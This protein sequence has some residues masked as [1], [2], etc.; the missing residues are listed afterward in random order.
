[1]PLRISWWFM[2]VLAVAIGAYAL[3]QALLPVARSPLVAGMLAFSSLGSLTHFLAGSLVI[4]IGA[5]QLSKWLRQRNLALHRWLGRVY[6]IGV[7]FGGIAG[8]VMA[9]N[10]TGGP[11]THLGFGMLAVLWL[12]TT[13]KA[14]LSIRAGNIKEHRAWMLR[15][16]ALTLAAVT[17]R[18]YLPLF[19]LFGIPFEQAYLAI[20]W[21]CWVPN[22]LITE[23]VV[24]GTRAR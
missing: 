24:I 13:A 7:G 17:L 6:V 10:S 9:F 8:L 14:Y 12:G 23:W 22:L 11:V 5:L 20:A 18:L 15:S 21:L 4:V 1:M 16:Y 2:F 19:D 3:A